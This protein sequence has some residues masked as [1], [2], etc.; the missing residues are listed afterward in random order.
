MIHVNQTVTT[1]EAARFE[2][3]RIVEMIEWLGD[4]FYALTN[5]DPITIGDATFARDKSEPMKADGKPIGYGILIVHNPTTNGLY[6]VVPGDWLVR[7][8][9]LGY[10]IMSDENFRKRFVAIEAG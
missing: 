8:D 9:Q 5:G 1:F 6:A 3:D 2:R 4:D 7:D 10:L